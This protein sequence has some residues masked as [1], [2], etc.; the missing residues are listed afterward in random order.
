MLGVDLSNFQKQFSA[1]DAHALKVNGFEFAFIGRQAN[2][3]IWAPRQRDLL[4]EAGI[5]RIGEYLISLNGVWPEL[6]PETRY[7]AI[8][9]EP[10]SEF[11]TEDQIDNAINW[12]NLQGRTAMIYTAPRAWNALGLAHVTKYPDM[13]IP[14]WNAHY[15]EKANGLGLAEP[16]GGWTRCAI[17]QFTGSGHVAGIAYELDLN[18][19]D[20]NLWFEAPRNAEFVIPEEEP[21]VKTRPL[22]QAE[23]I[24]ALNEMAKA[25]GEAIN[26]L[27]GQTMFEVTAGYPY[28]PPQGTKWYLATGKQ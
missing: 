17:D 23:S 4:R 1:A 10:G 5:T 16:Y 28:E 9:V 12:I 21:E 19:C 18:S 25:H 24:A 22:S 26:D 13:G 20:P 11:V 7:V 3:R 6:F 8:D 15:D 27:N 14:L 2:N